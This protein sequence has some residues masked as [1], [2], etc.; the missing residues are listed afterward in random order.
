MS[1]VTEL[2]LSQIW[3]CCRSILVSQV[4]YTVLFFCRYLHVFYSTKSFHICSWIKLRTVS[5]YK[6]LLYHFLTLFLYKHS[7]FKV[8]FN[9]LTKLLISVL[10]YAYNMIGKTEY[11]VTSILW[12]QRHIRTLSTSKME[13]FANRVNCWES[14]SILAKNSIIDC[15]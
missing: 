8:S 6:Y 14:L 15:I 7:V 5:F 1:Y 13:F 2:Y 10:F 9:M 11:A 4:Y 12:S 3:T